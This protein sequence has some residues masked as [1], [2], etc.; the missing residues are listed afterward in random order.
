MQFL[1]N[2]QRMSINIYLICKKLD[3]FVKKSDFHKTSIILFIN[4]KKTIIKYSLFSLF[5]KLKNL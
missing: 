4:Q 1:K 2:M 5:V 3:M